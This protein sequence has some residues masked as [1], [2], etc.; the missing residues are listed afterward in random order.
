LHVA[1]DTAQP[2]AADWHPRQNAALAAA[3]GLHLHADQ[4][5]GRDR[6]P[7]PFRLSRVSHIV[8]RQAEQSW[9]AQ[10]QNRRGNR[11]DGTIARM[12]A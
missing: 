8:A 11:L 10:R 2:L 4:P 9:L 6:R 5:V 3:L 7:L 1:G 12:R